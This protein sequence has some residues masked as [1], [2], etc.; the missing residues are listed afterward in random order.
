VPFLGCPLAATVVVAENDGFRLHVSE[1]LTRWQGAVAD[2][3]IK[4][5]ASRAVTDEHATV[6]LAALEG[7]V[8]V[9][10]R[11]PRHWTGIPEELSFGKVAR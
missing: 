5:G 2:V 8:R 7:A 6:L 11:L 10:P 1:L 3:Y 4:F 9:R